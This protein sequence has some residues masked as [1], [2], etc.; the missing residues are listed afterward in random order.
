MALRFSLKESIEVSFVESN[1][2]TSLYA[3]ETIQYC[4]LAFVNI[5]KGHN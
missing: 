5:C 2:I 4:V 3:R 1:I